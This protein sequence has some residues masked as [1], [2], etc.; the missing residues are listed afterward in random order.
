MSNEPR[1]MIL[2]ILNSLFY[3]LFIFS[4]FAVTKPLAWLVDL[5]SK[6]EDVKFLE[7]IE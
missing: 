5:T 2:D 6:K 7:G 4:L 1:P 3:G